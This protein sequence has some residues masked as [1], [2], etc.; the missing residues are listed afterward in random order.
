MGEYRKRTPCLVQ[1]TAVTLNWIAH[2]AYARGGGRDHG[3]FSSEIACVR[4]RNRGVSETRDTHAIR[5]GERTRAL[6]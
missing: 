1:L 3:K 2:R 4:V 5:V 6:R